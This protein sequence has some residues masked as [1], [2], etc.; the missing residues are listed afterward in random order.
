MK[1]ALTLTVLGFLFSAFTTSGS[2][3]TS[4]S[5]EK[6]RNST[7]RGTITCPN[8]CTG[9]CGPDDT[10]YLS[11]GSDLLYER[12]TVKFVNKKGEEIAA[13][14]SGQTHKKIEFRPY[15]RNAST[16]YNLEIKKDDIWNALNF[17]DRRGNVKINGVNFSAL[18]KLRSEMNMGKKV[19][20]TFI[21]IPGDARGCRSIC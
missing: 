8:G 21:G 16:R 9:L 1:L 7:C 14:L 2:A 20:M 4:C 15:R 11:C 10:C 12:I 5:C 6:I 13:T 19:S 18:R 3:Q 17:L